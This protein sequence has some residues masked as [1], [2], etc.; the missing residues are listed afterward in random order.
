MWQYILYDL[1]V[2]N[3]WWPKIFYRGWGVIIFRE[4]IVEMY[5]VRISSVI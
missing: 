1:A 5:H 4:L 2:H 3:F